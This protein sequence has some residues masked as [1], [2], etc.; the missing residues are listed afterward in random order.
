MR[1][2][3]DNL[4]LWY[5]TSDTPAPPAVVVSGAP[6][7]ITVAVAPVDASNRVSILYRVNGEAV[8]TVAARWLRMD[9]VASAQHFVATLGPFRSGDTVDYT[10][11][12]ESAG[13][14]V[15]PPEDLWQSPSSFAVQ[16]AAA[17]VSRL[18]TPSTLATVRPF[19][20]AREAIGVA[21]P[22]RNGGG[23]N[24]GPGGGGRGAGGAGGGGSGG[25]GAG[26]GT[27]TGTTF[28]VSGR[29]VLDN[30]RPAGAVTL[31]LY[32]VDFGGVATRVGEV[33]ADEQGNYVLSHA[34]AGDL[35]NLEVRTVDA[36]G[37][38]VPL[39]DTVFNASTDEKLNLV[40]PSAIRTTD[41]EHARIS[42]DLVKVVASSANLAKA[43][44]DSQQQDLSLLHATTGWDARLVAL[45]ARAA[46]LTT[47][48]GLSEEA[49]YG[50]FRVGLPNEPQQL[51]GIDTGVLDMSLKAARAAG[52]IGLTD[53]Q[54]EQAKTAFTAFA[55]NTRKATAAPGTLSSYGQLLSGV[56]SDDLQGPFLEGF[57]K[58]NG[59]P[60]AL[61]AE[62]AKKGIGQQQISILKRQGKLAYLTRNNH[63]LTGALQGETEDFARLADLDLYSADA[64]KTRLA[65][66]AAEAK[67]QDLN[68]L[69]PP[70]YIGD[71]RVDAYT[72]DLARKVRMSFGTRTV[73]R[74]VEKGDLKQLGGADPAGAGALLR[75]AEAQGFRL[76]Q[77]P[78]Q[79]FVKHNQ[80]KVFP[81]ATAPQVA[82]G[83]EMLKK[84]QRAYQ[85]T[86][87]HESMKVLDQLGLGSAHDVIAYGP[88]DFVDQYGDSFP[89]GEAQLIFR[90]SQ[91]IGYVVHNFVTA[92]QQLNV[93]PPTY[94]TS[95]AQQRRDA[96]RQSLVENFPTLES[97]FGSLD[98]CE[99]EECESV[100]GAAAYLVDI[101]KFLDPD[102][103][104]WTNFLNDWHD[105]HN[106]APY[107]FTDGAHLTAWQQAHPGQ[108]HTEKTPYQVF[109]ERRPDIPMLPLT[110]ENTNTVL[111]YIDVVNEVLEYFVAHDK[112]DSDSVRDTSGVDSAELL[113]EPQYIVPEAYDKLRQA[114]FP[115]G[116]PFNLWL[117]MVRAF[118]AYFDTPFWQVLETFRRSDDLFPPASN[119]KPY[120]RAAIFLESLGLSLEQVAVFSSTTLANWFS[121]YGYASESDALAALR[122]AKTLSRRLELSYQEV[123]D[124]IK[125]GFINPGLQSL[126]TLDKL[127]VSVE[128]VFR[129]TGQTG[130]PP[131][132]ADEQQAFE[133]RLDGM[134]AQF[135][136]FNAR[137]WL[138]NTWTAGTFRGILV[139]AD[140]SGGCSFDDTTIQY[141]DGTAADAIVFLKINLF[142]R[143]W[144]LLGWTIEETDRALQT[145]L[146]S[147]SPLTGANLGT[148]F[149]SALLY[150]S[151]LKAL[152]GR[153][154]IG[155]NSRIKLLTFWS[156][157]PTTGHNPLYAR[158]FLTPAVLRIDALFDDPL[159]NYLSNPE[160]PLSKHLLAVQGAIGLTA[161]D[162][163]AVL[164]AAGLDPAAAA[165]SVSNLSLLYRHSLLAKA[166]HI[167]IADLLA[168]K[169]LS[170]IDPFKPVKA[171]GIASLD[172]DYPF[173]KTL[174]FLDVA[175]R[176]K[177]SG[178]TIEDLNYLLRHRFDPVGKYRTNPNAMLSL[179]K[180]LSDGLA[181]IKATYA[182]PADVSTLTD[183]VLRQNLSLALPADVVETF[184]GMWNGTVSYQAVQLNVTAANALKA[185]EYVQEADISLS[186]D[187]VLQSQKLTF[188]GVPL[189]ARIAQLQAAHASALFAALL[190]DVQTQA[191]AFFDKQLATFLTAADFD[192]LFT[193]IPESLPDSQRQ[194]QLLAKRSRL[195]NAF[196]PYLQRELDRRFVIQTLAARLGSDPS[197]TEALLT[198]STLLTDP[199]DANKTLLDAF[200]AAGTRGVGASYFASQDGTGAALATATTPSAATD[201][202]PPGAN[203]AHFS[204]YFQVRDAGAYR[205]AAVC[206]KQTSQ[207][208]FLLD[209][210]PDA[211]L[212][213]TA[214]SDGATISGLVTLKAGVLYGFTFDARTLN[215][216]D[217]RLLV[218]GEK[219]PNDT[220]GQ[221][222]LYPRVAVDRVWRAYILLTK[223]LRLI[224]GLAFDQREVQYLLTHGTDFDNL[225][226][227]QLPT[228]GSDDS[229]TK[230]TALFTAFLRLARY[231]G[232][233]ADLAGGADDLIGIFEKARQ[234]YSAS[235]PPDQA[236]GALLGDLSQRF[237]DLT[238][239]DPAI[240]QA[241]ATQLG[242]TAETIP[243]TDGLQHLTIQQFADDRGIQ[244][245][246]DALQIV[247]KLGVSVA[248]IATWGT[249]T[250]NAQVASDLRN[251]AKAAYDPEAWQRIAQSIFDPL[252]QLKRDA[253]VAYIMAR[254]NFDRREQLFEYFLIDT[255]MEPIVQTSR[256]VVAMSAVQTFI[257][258]CLL[259]LEAEVHPSSVNAGQWEWMKR[260][261]VWEA[262]RRI[263]LYPE[264]WLEPEFRR[265]KTNFYTELEGALFKGDISED[266]VEDAFFKYLLGLESVAK[267]EIVTMYSEDHPR[268]PGSNTLHVIGRTASLPHKYFY[269]KY[270]FQA[271]TPWVPVTAEI[272]G[273]HVAIVLWRERLHLLWVTFLD[274]AKSSGALANPSG[275]DKPL[276]EV[277]LGQLST[278]MQQ[279]AAKHDVEVQ[280]H[281]SEYFQGKWTA[282][283]S[284]GLANPIRQEVDPPFN[285]S[286]VFIH[287]SKEYDHAGEEGPLIIHLSSPVSGSFRVVSKNSP[288]EARPPG[289]TSDEEDVPWI[290][291]S[292]TPNPMSE[293]ATQYVGRGTLQVSYVEEIKT[294]DGHAP[295]PTTTTKTIIQPGDSFSILTINNQFKLI[296]SEIGSLVVPFFYQDSR[297]TFFVEPT[298][299]ERTIDEWTEWAIPPPPPDGGWWDPNWWN[300]LP[301]GSQWPGGPVPWDSIDPRSKYQ[302][303][304]SRDW[305]TDN[306][307]ALRY[308]DTVI[309]RQGGL[310]AAALGGRSTPGSGWIGG[311]T[312]VT[313]GGQQ[314]LVGATGMRGGFTIV[315]GGGLSSATLGALSQRNGLL[316]G[317]GKLGGFS[318]FG[319]V[320]G[321]G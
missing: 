71:Q 12:C 40:A 125:T 257:Q 66:A 313:M 24:G 35:A 117:A 62:A 222:P 133:K 89:D 192:P 214:A 23:G 81:N 170:G 114:R 171:T 61:W 224:G 74:L 253:L 116:L 316:S 129:Y 303:Q 7:S 218:Q 65:N 319:N 309:G 109:I 64:W 50:L 130:Y 238:R 284:S 286:E 178:L 199:T 261:R 232:L 92:A 300:S 249:P 87:S 49:L 68:K 197:L 216:G 104:V 99:C 139:L 297:Y 107:P 144:R 88:D 271:W 103:L 304:Q 15:P 258:R 57:Y 33:R 187:H 318:G 126:V 250:P 210:V 32:A 53:A 220:L 227:S 16:E 160:E 256:I 186:Y 265:D 9:T 290:P 174:H 42:S 321:S 41:S 247:Q 205:F 212:S 166:L 306:A 141:A 143:L 268:D 119:P 52:V 317:G 231:L 118:C 291:Y 272:E 112:L 241:V 287:V 26:G 162:G 122:N 264:N 56:L 165:L 8:E 113:A 108:S 67:E 169:E 17:V 123:V 311:R 193:P 101:L 233:R 282:R 79:T 163:N 127:G 164:Q 288:P 293:S 85:M 59:T 156:S 44:E 236:K 110:C 185:A 93:A 14:Q 230:A 73:A 223:V 239:R 22:Q 273:D 204:G 155:P 147:A 6:I 211:V 20:A 90:K 251:T 200:D 196:L 58:S 54:I 18:M 305:A 95:P 248:S 135:A 94:A 157:L 1:I 120:Y 168:L 154:H 31:R 145:F 13:R 320:M 173:T 149:S 97:L 266:L 206:G 307:T 237:A 190:T 132:T 152:D 75:R 83:T 43:R 45:A 181:S 202:K 184:F 111:P 177:D 277:T 301:V 292:A 153:L 76:G 150:L 246:W 77:M 106:G 203:S 91:Q 285:A 229:A 315:S 244:R 30:G 283:Q 219:L 136:G 180:T 240:V 72:A 161:K 51:A 274:K 267:L 226:L 198:D 82:A 221:L 131:M 105:K 80:A 39:S 115:V 280:L 176:V 142:V 278:A 279:S 98:F 242:F 262:N 137:T 37:N 201:G 55:T 27:G 276:Q 5:G 19:S 189:A 86:P 225:N 294:V 29:I 124:L 308:G 96:A 188:T 296:D 194:I 3:H 299:E 134:T 28:R 146:P 235:M 102:P 179:V 151:H 215:G 138:N 295:Q 46:S 208:E 195:A 234:T 140:P 228:R 243:A 263:F 2:E 25:A 84:A 21:Q 4:V 121:L 302:V 167:S 159:G 269:R 182:V 255:G 260:Y 270:A 34:A 69:V 213:G 314:A 252:R 47:S 245:L 183:D 281:W 100:L 217:V 254:L 312:T 128:D 70:S 289:Q 48:T 158:L 298:L 259:N 275:K 209:T 10:P 38:E 78:V 11:V 148:A 36:K 172:D 191:H 175:D 60:G 310:D 63:H 207:A